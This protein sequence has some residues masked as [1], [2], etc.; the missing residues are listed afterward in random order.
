M[1][2]VGCVCVGNFTDIKSTKTVNVLIQCGKLPQIRC[3]AFFF[4]SITVF[5]FA[6]T[7]GKSYSS[8]QISHELF[9]FFPSVGEY[10][11]LAIIKENI[12]ITHA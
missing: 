5:R 4:R 3:Q 12:Y 11:F 10:F 8:I 1:P 2:T 6:A 9:L 7:F